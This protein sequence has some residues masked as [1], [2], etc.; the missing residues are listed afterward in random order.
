MLRAIREFFDASVAAPRPEGDRHSIE[1]AT[2]ALLVEVVRVDAD[3][4]DAE[5]DA[6]LRAVRSKFGLSGDEA[7]TLI[8]LAEQEMKQANDYFQFTSLINRHFTP[9][10]KGKV[11]E[12]MWRVA[13][14]DAEIS[15]HERHLLRKIADLLH[16]TPGEYVAAQE[17]A[18]ASTPAP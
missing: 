1:L 6:V 10:Q 15:A 18:R 16:L 5:R 2:A 12:L 3:C 9:E 17:R 14:A 7:E 13:Y 4:T 11:M 8:S